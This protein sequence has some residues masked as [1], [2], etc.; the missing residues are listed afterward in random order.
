MA[1]F[2]KLVRRVRTVAGSSSNY[3]WVLAA[4]RAGLRRFNNTLER[5]LAGLSIL[6]WFTAFWAVLILLERY[7]VA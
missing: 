4:L 6:F 1:H 2:R 7:L 3:R 5:L